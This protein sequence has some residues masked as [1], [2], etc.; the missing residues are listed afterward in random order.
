MTSLMPTRNM[1]MPTQLFHSSCAYV[2]I[3][4]LFMQYYE[5]IIDYANFVRTKLILLN[6]KFENRDTPQTGAT[7]GDARFASFYCHY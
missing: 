6:C 5:C 7:F 4:P 2:P 3:Y 1:A